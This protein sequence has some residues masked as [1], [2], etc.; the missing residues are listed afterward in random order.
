VKSSAFDNE[1][2]GANLVAFLRQKTG[3]DAV[4]S[5]LK[6]YTVGFSWM[7]FG[8]DVEWKDPEKAGRPRRESLIL[9][10]GP[11]TGL[12]APY[13]A[14]PQFA[15]LQAFHGTAVPVPRPHWYREDSDAFGAPFF[16]CDRVEGEAP[17]PWVSEGKEAFPPDV[18]ESLAEQ[19]VAALAALH[20]FDWHG[21]ALEKLGPA[22]DERSA[23]AEQLRFWGDLLERWSFRPYPMLEWTLS[24][25]KAHQPVAPRVTVVHGDYRTGNFLESGGRI[26]AI[27]DWELVHLG[28]PLEDLGWV[29]MRSF[30]G[31]SPYM[32]H[33]MER[34]RFYERY[35][36]LSGIPVSRETVRFYEALGTFKLAVIHVAAARCFEDGLFKDLRLATLG[37]HLPRL[38]LQIESTIEGKA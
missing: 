12:F 32:C 18:R 22:V 6:R 1:A 17:L 15:A 11:P 27:L 33:L 9:R 21:T 30:R 16:I 2:V 29:C 19:F 13:Q 28:D 26:T 35:A 4:V 38:I 20:R 25:L 24:W 8:F 5:G 31:R 3:S 23:A 34:D 36:E 10:L 14:F 37:I 7:T